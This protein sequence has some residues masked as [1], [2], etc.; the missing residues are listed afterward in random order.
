VRGL[1]GFFASIIVSG[2]LLREELPAL[3]LMLSTK[4]KGEGIDLVT[5]GTVIITDH[6]W[7]Q[8]AEDQAIDRL[9]RIGQVH[10]SVQVI[11]LHIGDTI[12]DHLEKVLAK[13]N[14]VVEKITVQ[15]EVLRS[16]WQSRKGLQYQI[17]S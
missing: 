15:K 11:K 16:I 4:K 10:D 1:G 12:D 13:K 3:S 5:A 2:L 17:K 6:W 8:A 9:H 14:E 7:N